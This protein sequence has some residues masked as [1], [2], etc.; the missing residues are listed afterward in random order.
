M[1][2]RKALFSTLFLGGMVPAGLLAQSAGK[3][4]RRAR[5]AAAANG[6]DP[7]AGA[8]ADPGLPGAL[9]HVA[10]F[11]FKTWDIRPYTSIPTRVQGPPEQSLID[12]I[13][14][15]TDR[16]EWHGEHLTVLYADRNRLYAYNSPEVLTKVGEIVERFVNSTSETLRLRVQYV[17]AVDPRWRYSVYSNLTYV[18]SGPQ[19]QQIWTIDS[20]NAAGILAQMQVQQGFRLLSKEDVEIVNGQTIGIDT[21]APRTFVGGLVQEAGGAMTFQPRSETILEGVF[22]RISPLLNFEGT[23]VDAKM[24]LRVNTVRML[25][26]TKVIAPREIG[27]FETSI[28]VP[29]S[30]M[31]RLEQTVRNWRL[32]Q[33]LIISCGVH[34]GILDK[35]TGLFN[36][37]I[38]GT[39][40]TAT[41]VLVFLDIETVQRSTASRGRGRVLSRSRRRDDEETAAL[42]GD[43]E[44]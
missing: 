22:L 18:G 30:T 2:R 32:G 31:T 20:R 9:A 1:N 11:E 35:K 3:P 24:D 33:A 13:L 43:T 25:H 17:A 37:Q 42:D 41:E 38:P 27:P 34:P 44:R 6:E 12:W 21:K 15:R 14:A 39:Y 5:T 8:G 28:D 40:P 7:D 36:L 10:G 4:V 16:S 29:D 23:A 19:G 26:R